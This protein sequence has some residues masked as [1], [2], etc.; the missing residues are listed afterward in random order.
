MCPLR[1]WDVLELRSALSRAARRFTAAVSLACWQ[2]EGSGER[3]PSSA[4]GGEW[5][6]SFACFVIAPR[7]TNNQDRTRVAL[8]VVSPVSRMNKL[9]TCFYRLAKTF[10]LLW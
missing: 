3:Q 5:R 1:T 9:L 6:R 7:A 10:N 2:W 8:A 4:S